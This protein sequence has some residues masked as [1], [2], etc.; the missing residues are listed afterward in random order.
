MDSHSIK[1]NDQIH[2]LTDAIHE[3]DSENNSDVIVVD[4]R[5]YKNNP[6]IEKEV[7][8]LVDVLD[9]HQIGDRIPEDLYARLED[10]VENSVRKLLPEIAERIIK[11]E[12]T[13]LKEQ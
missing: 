13:K 7:Y 11:A 2:D 8:N 6:S 10:M 3:V 9:D 12:I 5:G 4:G 1:E